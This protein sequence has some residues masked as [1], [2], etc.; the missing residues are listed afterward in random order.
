MET[1]KSE[2]GCLISVEHDSGA[3]TPAIKKELSNH[4]EINIEEGKEYSLE[5]IK[6]MDLDH[7][8]TE[9]GTKMWKCFFCPKSYKQKL[10][11]IQHMVST[12][13]KHR[14]K[15]DSCGKEFRHPQALKSHISVE[16]E[17]QPHECDICGKKFPTEDRKMRH[18]NSSK[19][20]HQK[21]KTINISTDDI[22]KEPLDS[23]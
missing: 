11:T 13:T 15:C 16:H 8:I 19:N 1:W 3:G 5:D 17:E 2:G 21:N 18:I 14:Y 20:C 10:G 12:H 6:N 22:K 4:S 23:R 9:D 7:E